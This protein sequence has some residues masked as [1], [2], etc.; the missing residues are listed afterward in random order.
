M[1]RHRTAA[2]LNTE[3]ESPLEASLVWDITRGDVLLS[4]S[5]CWPKCLE[6]PLHMAEAFVV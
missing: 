2:L 5:L 4:S 6:T 1:S 3:P